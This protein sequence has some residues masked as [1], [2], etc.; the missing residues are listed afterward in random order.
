M[1]SYLLFVIGYLLMVIGYWL[2]VIFR[3]GSCKQ[4][5]AFFI[6]PTA[7]FYFRSPRPASEL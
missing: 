6:A 2:L 3:L 4:L 1:F 7:N 5:K